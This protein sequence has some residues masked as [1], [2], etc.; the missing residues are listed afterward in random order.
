MSK[1]RRSIKI[2]FFV[3]VINFDEMSFI[4]HFFGMSNFD[5]F[6]G[7]HN[8]LRS[9]TQLRLDS[10]LTGEPFTEE[11]EH[12]E[13]PQLA[14]RQWVRLTDEGDFTDSTTLRLDSLAQ[15]GRPILVVMKKKPQIMRKLLK[16]I[17][18]VPEE[19]RRTIPLL[20]IDDEADQASTDTGRNGKTTPTNAHIRFDQKSFVYSRGHHIYKSTQ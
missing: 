18:K 20:V 5:V 3:L 16:W 9:Q 2:S 14:N 11:V 1:K 17:K 12:V 8:N 6:A 10:E 4:C 19:V 13:I 7:L 15:S